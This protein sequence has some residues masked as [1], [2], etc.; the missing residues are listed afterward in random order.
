MCL[1]VLQK[2]ATLPVHSHPD[3]TVFSRVIYG[4]LHVRT[5]DLLDK[6]ESSKCTNQ[7]QHGAIGTT[8]PESIDTRS[9]TTT[10]ATTK[11]L[12]HSTT[13]QPPSVPNNHNHIPGRLIRDS[14]I[15]GETDGLQSILEINS[16][17]PNLHSFTAESDHVVIF[18][19][20]FPPYDEQLRTCTYYEPTEC[21]RGFGGIHEEDG[22]F[23]SS[24][25]SDDIELELEL[26]KQQEQGQQEYQKN[27]L[28]QEVELG[29][30]QICLNT[31][32]Q[33]QQQ[34][35]HQ[36]QQQRH[37]MMDIDIPHQPHQQQSPLVQHPQQLQAS[38]A[39]ATSSSNPVT[40]PS[41]PRSSGRRKKRGKKTKQ[42]GKTTTTATTTTTASACSISSSTPLDLVEL[43]YNNEIN[44][45]PYLGQQIRQEQLDRG[46]TLT[47]FDL[48]QLGLRVCA[49]VERMNNGGGAGGGSPRLTPKVVDGHMTGN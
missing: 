21:I 19:L 42:P 3:M 45:I 47:D 44:S 30:D 31:P 29:V 23:E 37:G 35:Q 28:H 43:D 46:M 34:K 6:H 7:Q 9:P 17:T 32:E 14:I 2:G 39:V 16:N 24:G 27:Q 41:N 33:Q 12:R 15:S 4:D 49:M 26:E 10:P 40:T 20:L 1:F 18:D 22:V 8:G 38:T 13:T 25:E 48:I 36:Q 11:P 5:Y